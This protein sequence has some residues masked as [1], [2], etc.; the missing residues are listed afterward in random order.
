MSKYSYQNKEDVSLTDDVLK[1]SFLYSRISSICEISLA[2]TMILAFTVKSIAQVPESQD[3][4]EPKIDW[5]FPMGGEQGSS[6][7]VKFEGKL[8]D[9]VYA[10]WSPKEGLWGKILAVQEISVNDNSETAETKKS[11]KKQRVLVKLEISSK[12]K[13]GIYSLRLVSKRGVS[14]PVTFVVN[15]E[16]IIQESSNSNRVPHQ[17]RP[18][19]HPVA[20]NGAIDQPGEVNYYSVMVS[21]NEELLF[22]L[23]TVAETFQPT[24]RLYDSKGSWLSDESL[25]QLEFNQETEYMRTQKLE[26]GS[27]R[28]TRH[29]FNKAG[30]Y[31][32]AIGSIYGKSDSSF[33][34]QLKITGVDSYL[35]Q[36][37][38]FQHDRVPKWSERKYT[39]KLTPTRIDDLWSRTIRIGKHE[40]QKSHDNQLL[41]QSK[42]SLQDSE[43]SGPPMFTDNDVTVVSD[44][45][46]PNGRQV[47]AVTLN[48]PSLVTGTIENP[49]DIDLYH[50]KLSE[51]RSLVFEIETP[52]VPPSAFNP[53]LKVLDSE[54]HELINNK[55]RKIALTRQDP[56]FLIE[57][58]KQHLSDKGD[59][60]ITSLSFFE[61]LEA[62]MIVKFAVGG[63]YYLQIGD[64]T[65]QK[66]GS[67]FKYRLMVRGQ[68][69]HIG[70]LNLEEDRVNL[71]LNQVKKIKVTTGLEEG[72][73]GDV[74]FSLE[75]LPSG[76]RTL[77]ATTV[78]PK[79]PIG[80]TTERQ[81]NFSAFVNDVIILFRA[82]PAAPITKM[83]FMVKVWA[84]PV[85]NNRL[86]SK[87]LVGEMPLMVT[88]P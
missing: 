81:E 60:G 42:D 35:R 87:L 62:K 23:F 84:Q 74:A 76:V 12:A 68:I 4:T 9:G 40:S 32:V 54:G 72:F 11:Q 28:Q 15:G 30:H 70:E 71:V 44:E 36:A 43:N 58:L 33:V 56:I 63:S 14:N 55:H 79:E 1:N 59:C 85:L 5:V 73:T 49:G 7:K 17:S 64:I 39:R 34:Y 31:I 21:S 37:E 65:S 29:R 19:K 3:P 27:L 8:L 66:G 24:I 78:E 82:D 47:Q 38:W 53:S 13:T 16:R 26:L 51:A 48:L 25:L 86:G 20:I 18:V 61:S 69:P 80:P 67:G 52:N 46:E 88:T 83:P 41:P 75:G 77:T 57:L 50:F 6:I 2:I 45:K 10:V 22:Q